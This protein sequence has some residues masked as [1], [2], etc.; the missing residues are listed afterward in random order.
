MPEIQTLGETLMS[1]AT[2]A[3]DRGVREC[4]RERE[5]R[6]RLAA[7]E[8]EVQDLRRALGSKSG[9]A[10]SVSVTASPMIQTAQQ[11]EMKNLQIQQ[12]ESDVR[13]GLRELVTTLAASE[14]SP[15]DR[16]DLT[17]EVAELAAS[18]ETGSSFLDKAK[19]VAEKVAGFADR[20]GAGAQ[21]V[22]AAATNIVNLI[23]TI[24][25]VL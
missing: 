10:T 16:A 25:A 9:G 20:A 11:V 1:Y 6:E 13:N 2:Y 18:P 12:V 17:A 21:P 8:Q 23:G 19:T 15:Q 4:Q 24:A 14:L 3:V 5:L 7:A 22:L